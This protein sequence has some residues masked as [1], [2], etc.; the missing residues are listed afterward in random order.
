MYDGWWPRSRRLSEAPSQTKNSGPKKPSVSANS[1]LASRRGSP[2]AATTSPKLKPANMIDTCVA[3]ASA[4]R[5]N[6]MAS[7]I[8]NT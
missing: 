6:R 7:W 3:T 5:L 1:C 4:A 2:T 8:R